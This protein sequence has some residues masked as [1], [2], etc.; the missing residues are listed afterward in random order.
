MDRY[1]S[2]APEE[3]AILSHLREHPVI[4]YSQIDRGLDLDTVSAYDF[5]THLLAYGLI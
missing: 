3:V 5:I 1:G 2:L 4:E